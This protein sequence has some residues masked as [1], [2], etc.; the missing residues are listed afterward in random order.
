MEQVLERRVS[1]AVGMN[2]FDKQP[3]CLNALF[4]FEVASDT[5][6]GEPAGIRARWS[7]DCASTVIPCSGARLVRSLTT[8]S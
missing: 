1:D 3:D 7:R 4:R 6:D 8:N 5:F 2:L